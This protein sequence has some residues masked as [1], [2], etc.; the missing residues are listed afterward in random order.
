MKI[1][2][3]GD[4][5]C[6]A[7]GFGIVNKNILNGL[8]ERGFDIVQLGLNYFGDPH[9]ELFKIYPT[10]TEDRQG[11]TKLMSVL[12]SEN[13]DILMTVNDIWALTWIPTI[14]SRYRAETGNVI[15]WVAYFPIDGLPVK[16][17]WV[18]FIR[19]KV[20]I[21]VTYTQWAKQAIE[22]VDGSLKLDY[23][24]HGVDK[25]VF[26]PNEKIKT[27]FKQQLSKQLGREVNFVI[28][29]VGRNQ[30]RKRLPELLMAYNGFIQE[31]NIEDAILYLHTNTPDMGWDLREL[32]NTLK[33]PNDQVLLTPKFSVSSGMEEDYVANL[34]RLFDV[35][36][37]PTIGEG[38]GL[39][40]IEAMASGC[41]VVSTNCSV[42]PE[43]LNGAGLLINPGHYEILTKDHELIRPVPSVT[44]MKEEFTDLYKNPD[45]LEAYS[46]LAIKR[47]EAFA[48]WNIDFWEQKMLEAKKIIEN[49]TSGLKFDL[50]LF[51][52]I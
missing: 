18:D 43:I 20:D 32:K 34:Y 3:I 21:P 47:S 6:V 37:L 39:P 27:Q 22:Q 35:F 49:K 14:L 17:S 26:S 29:Y 9:G 31:N 12:K 8:L 16:K 46:K 41:A 38:F 52:E 2:N 25:N 48:S 24:Y 50:D 11:F 15:P 33:I 30:P 23:V 5:A 13:P 40:L 51:E 1:L 10:S 36:C 42:V 45:M 7:T 19:F 44:E 28:G 4:A